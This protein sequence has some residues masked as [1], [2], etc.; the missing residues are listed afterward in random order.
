MRKRKG[1]LPRSGI[2]PE[3]RVAR[4]A[5]T[6]GND[7]DQRQPHRGYGWPLLRNF[8]KINERNPGWGCSQILVPR[9]AAK[10]GNPGLW[11]ETASR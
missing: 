1:N 10:R 11:V 4:L 6:L 5:A 7:G 3:P 9:V 2:D 8:W